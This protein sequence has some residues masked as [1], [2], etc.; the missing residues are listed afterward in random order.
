MVHANVPLRA[1][2]ASG[3]RPRGRNQTCSQELWRW[4]P[5]SSSVALHLHNNSSNL[6]R[7]QARARPNRTTAPSPSAGMRTR[8]RYASGQL[9]PRA[10]SRIPQLVQRSPMRPGPAQT[11]RRAE[12]PSGRPE[13][14]TA[15]F[16]SHFALS[17]VNLAS[18]ASRPGVS[19]RAA[20]AMVVSRRV[21]DR[22]AI[23]R[24]ASVS[25]SPAG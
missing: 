10:T 24:G 3:R 11:Q 19:V 16:A 20:L 15:K 25:D 18:S 4:P 5:R 13:W 21:R 6:A 2:R 9:I 8:T 14:R 7:S 22:P 17:L 1:Y 12:L 23:R